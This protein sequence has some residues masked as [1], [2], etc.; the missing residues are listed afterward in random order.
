MTPPVQ[1]TGPLNVLAICG[2]LRRGSFNRGL[3]EAAAELAPDEMHMSIYPDIGDIP[4][5]NFDVERAGVPQ[6]VE[7]FKAAIADADSLLIA[8]PEYNYGT[9]GVL[10][11]AIDWASRPPGKSPLQRKPI[12]LV[13]AS[14]GR[15]GTIRAQLH[16]RQVFI[17]TESY[18]MLRPEVLVQTAREKF[19]ESG[20]LTDEQTRGFLRKHLE[21][22]LQWARKFPLE[23]RPTD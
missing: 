22:L 12:G 17:F 9:T 2:S 6:S 11:N 7:A 19:D 13:G 21:A 8:T 3:L 18:V 15:G 16:L 20:R 10:K 14:G 23:A 5:Y 1:S 4:P